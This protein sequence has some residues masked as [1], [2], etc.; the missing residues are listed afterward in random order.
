MLSRELE[1]ALIVGIKEARRRRHEYVTVEHMLFGLLH[2]DLARHIIS[3]CGGSNEHLKERLERFFLGGMP[4]LKRQAPGSW[5]WRK[6]A[7][8]PLCVAGARRLGG[9]M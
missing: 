9:N 5:P 2:D 8:A 7:M 4:V 1:Q 6:G 3:A